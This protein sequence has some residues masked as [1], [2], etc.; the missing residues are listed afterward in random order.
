M[1]NI[2]KRI[3]VI[4][5][6]GPMP[7][8]YVD[9]IE[10][11]KKKNLGYK[12]LFWWD[13]RFVRPPKEGEHPF[14][15][16]LLFLRARGITAIDVRVFEKN[17]DG[18]AMAYYFYECAK[19]LKAPEGPQHKPNYGSASDILR[20]E[21]LIRVPGVYV[22]TDIIAG[23]LGDIAVTN[24]LGGLVNYYDE[25]GCIKNVTNDI[26]A[27]HKPDLFVEYRN[28]IVKNYDSGLKKPTEF[29]RMTNKSHNADFT[30]S[31]SGPNALKATLARLG[32]DFMAGDDIDS[33]PKLKAMLFPR[34]RVT[35]PAQ[36]ANTWL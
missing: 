3:H 25:G 11:W 13:S 2:P 28:T 22:D 8:K 19:L 34:E 7:A 5:V 12:V 6:G 21:V 24:P 18:A 31:A 33:N 10:D 1:P 4:W 30:V 16:E 20:V 35:V 9:N 32:V 29:M 14:K 17:F 26:M 15:D 23:D 36:S 27:S